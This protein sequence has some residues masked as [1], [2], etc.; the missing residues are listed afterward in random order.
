[1]FIFN[2]LLEFYEIVYK[3][4]GRIVVVIIFDRE[5]MGVGICLYLKKM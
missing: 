2:V 3:F 1:M 5:C 4:G